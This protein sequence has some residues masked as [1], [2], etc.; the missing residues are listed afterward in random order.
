[1]KI[2]VLALQGAVAEHIRSFEEAGAEAVAVKRTEQ[3]EELRGLLFRAERARRSVSLCGNMD[4]W[5]RLRIFQRRV[6]R[7]LALVR[8]LSSLLTISKDKRKPFGTDGYDGGAECFWP[9]AGKL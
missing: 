7:Y 6:S 4:L 2:G 9:P 1:M 3:L 8:V 5:M